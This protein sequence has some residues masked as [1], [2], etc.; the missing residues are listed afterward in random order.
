MIHSFTNKF[1][2][3]IFASEE[4]DDVPNV[5]RKRKRPFDEGPDGVELGGVKKIKTERTS[6][7]FDLFSTNIVQNMADWVQKKTPALFNWGSVEDKPVNHN[8]NGVRR[9][10][11]HH[12]DSFKKS[13]APLSYSR[14]DVPT[15]YRPGTFQVY[16]P[17][18]KQLTTDNLSRGPLHKRSTESRTVQTDDLPGT[19]IPNR[20]HRAKEKF[21]TRN[22]HQFSASES[23]RLDER[24]RYQQLLQKFTTVPLGE[25][26]DTAKKEIKHPVRVPELTKF[27]FKGNDSILGA[28]VG[29]DVKKDVPSRSTR[30]DSVKFKVH[31]S[32][33]STPRPVVNGT[34]SPVDESL[35]HITD[36]SA[37]PSM[38]PDSVRK[39]P[40][41]K[42]I[43]LTDDDDRVEI[44]RKS[45]PRSELS[46]PVDDYRASKFLSEDW[47]KDLTTKYS[48]KARELERQVAQEKIKTQVWDEQRKKDAEDLEKKIR[49]NLKIYQRE[50]VVIEDVPISDEEEEEREEKEE[51]LP[52]LTSE[53][54]SRITQCL[55][56][57]NGA[58]VL[59]DKFKQQ[60][61]RT[62][63]ATLGGL[64]WL[65]DEVINFYMNLLMDRGSK[66]NMPKVHAFN[67][68]FYP[69]ISQGGQ[70]SVRRWTKTVDVLAVDYII[71]PVH[72]GMHWCLA[73]INFKKKEIQYYDSMGG[74]N[75]KCLN[76]LKTYLCDES[77]EK[78]KKDFDL[79]GWNTVTM[80]DI[81]QQMN[82][83]D[84]GMFTC[85]FADYITR[86]APITFTQ[87]H[88]PYFR[89]RMV[90]E[91][92]TGK[93]LQ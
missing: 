19:L 52:E 72:L 40:P 49:V 71:V 21:I 64:N 9:N 23:V 35:I 66:T 93:L 37:I 51:V 73:V 20:P 86:E 81:P 56:R 22:K 42:I 47:I 80:K 88:M 8:G 50:P 41:P 29:P 61:T 18:Y 70:Q 14:N 15:A 17:T 1:K 12:T 54:E 10:G 7:F 62:D 85:K 24:A 57:G 78:K 63:I 74:T 79:N 33:K 91:I 28:T 31:P 69:K 44:T 30:Q 38:Q 3:L 11:D 68:F 75:Q 13:S 77:K 60:I 55:Q 5:D 58:D 83:S 32:Q 87:Q 67:T 4:K 25:T 48:S 76:L 16:E 26:G 27:Y 82:G 92:V 90:Y 34:T 36:I 65:N 46:T 39:Q 2:S 59:V 89:R 53:M 43:D 84:C 6:S 45:L